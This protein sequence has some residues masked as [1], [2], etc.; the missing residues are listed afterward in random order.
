MTRMRLLLVVAVAFLLI[1][2]AVG[3]GAW[4]Y[5]FGPN[6]IESA[7]L[8]PADT[9]LFASIPNAMEIAAGYETSHLK[10]LLESPNSQPAKDSLVNLIG[11]KNLELAQSFAPNLSGQS[12][13]AL[14]HVDIDKPE[15]TGFIAAMKPKAGMGDFNAYVEKVK[16]AFPDALKQGKTGTGNV[17]GTDYQWIQGPGSPGK[18]CVAQIGGW[19]VTTWGEA[20]LQDWI[21]RY[22][23]KSTTPSLAQNTDYQTSMARIGKNAMAVVYVNYHLVMDLVQKQMAKQDPA[24]ANYFSKKIASIGGLAIGTR[25]EDGEIVDRFSFLIP[26]Q[27]QIDGGLGAGPCPFETLKFTTL[28][29]RFYAA[30]SIDWKQ[31]WKNIQDQL[32]QTSNPLLGALTPSLQALKGSGIDLQHNVIDA[33]GSEISIQAEW[34]ADTTYPEAGLFLKVDKPEDFKPVIQALIEGTRR[35]FANTGTIKE[36]TSNGQTFASLEFLQASPISPT[37]TEDGPYFGLFLSENQAVR[38]FQRDPTIS[39]DHNPDFARQIGDRRK[40]A[41]QLVYVDSPQLL[42]R[43]YRMALPYLS[44]ASMFNKDVAAAMKG[45]TLPE[46]LAWLAP[47]GTWSLVVTPDDTGLQAYSVSGIGNQGIILTAG[48]GGSLA[49]A[50]S[51]GLIP[52]MPGVSPAQPPAGLIPTPPPAAPVAAPSPAAATLAPVAPDTV[53]APTNTPTSAPLSPPTPNAGQ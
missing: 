27:N 48:L 7:E 6:K 51:M 52:K 9:V 2:C 36:I 44:L 25:F 31:Y 34:N 8:V 12:F 5:F 14:T 39:L 47:M 46:N 4:W 19:I 26:H 22:H 24:T 15:Q 43:A 3:A 13:I 53:S 11:Q 21:E 45:K 20:P 38:S 10:T 30:S 1:V 41:S 37:V 16:T 17:A 35:A 18:I 33:L 32:S 40:G 42:D 23:R 28:S 50:Q 29:T 49:V